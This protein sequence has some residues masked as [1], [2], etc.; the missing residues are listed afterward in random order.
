[1]SAELLG[2]ENENEAVAGIE[3]EAVEGNE[4]RN[5]KDLALVPDRHLL[6]DVSLKKKAV[7]EIAI[8]AVKHHLEING[9]AI[10][11]RRRHR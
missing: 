7:E 9:T 5:A 3:N 1:M 10:E 4:A 8:V 2:N 6:V 11:D